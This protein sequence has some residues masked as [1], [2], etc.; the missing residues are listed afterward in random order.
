[1]SYSPMQLQFQTPEIPS[2]FLPQI[3]FCETTRALRM[4][5]LI[6][7][8]GWKKMEQKMETTARFRVS[9]G[10]ERKWRHVQVVYWVFTINGQ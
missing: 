3:Y 10:M 9:V 6:G 5:F 7:K 1:M 2:M 8:E 4:R